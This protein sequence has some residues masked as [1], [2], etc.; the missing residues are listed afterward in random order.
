MDAGKVSVYAVFACFEGVKAGSQKVIALVVFVSRKK[1][2]SRSD[3]LRRYFC[4]TIFTASFTNFFQSVHISVTD[5]SNFLH[6][7]WIYLIM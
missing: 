5:S 1:Q 3:K 6:V 7:S 4:K 2:R